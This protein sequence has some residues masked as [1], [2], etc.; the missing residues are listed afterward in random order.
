MTCRAADGLAAPQFSRSSRLLKTN[1][2]EKSHRP[3]IFSG[4]PGSFTVSG[5]AS[6]AAARVSV[7]GFSSKRFFPLLTNNMLSVRP[8]RSAGVAPFHCYYGP[9]RLPVRAAAQ[10][11]YS[12][13]ALAVASHP[14]GS[15][16]LLRLICPRALSPST[17]EGPMAAY[18]CCF[19]IGLVWLRLSRQIGHLRI[20]IEAESGS[21]ALRLA[22]SPPSRTSPITGTPARSAT[23]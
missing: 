3:E 20:P 19:T 7:V 9:L 18:A 17:P 15:P 6:P 22:C 16:R 11:M 8:L 21:L 5:I 12:L 13:P 1:G 10:V 4:S 2:L 14:P 23:C